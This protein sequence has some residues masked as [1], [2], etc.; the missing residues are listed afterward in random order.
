MNT[1]YY[2]IIKLK[3]NLNNKNETKRFHHISLDRLK[4]EINNFKNNLLSINN[5]YSIISID[6]Y[7]ISKLNN[8][9]T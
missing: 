3:N 1:G 9:N 2:A 7:Q 8:I 5:L 6:F 4:K